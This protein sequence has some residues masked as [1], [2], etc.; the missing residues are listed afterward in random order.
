MLALGTFNADDSQINEADRQFVVDTVRSWYQQD[1]AASVHS[2]SRLAART[3]ARGRKKRR[4]IKVETP[5]DQRAALETR[6]DRT[7]DGDD[8]TAR[9]VDSTVRDCRDQRKR[10]AG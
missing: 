8:A 9:F 5:D 7:G 2:T 10:P 6:L 3:L 1:P 4:L